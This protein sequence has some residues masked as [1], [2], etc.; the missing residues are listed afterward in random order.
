MI[1]PTWLAYYL[2][3]SFGQRLLMRKVLELFAP[4]KTNRIA[5][6]TVVIPPLSLVTEIET[7]ERQAQEHT[8]ASHEIWT[9]T[10]KGMYS[11]N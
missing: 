2:N 1:S 11:R 6:S 7:L 10:Q 5:I 8:L 3:T 4:F 9:A